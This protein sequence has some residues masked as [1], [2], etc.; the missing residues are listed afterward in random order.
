MRPEGT[1]VFLTYVSPHGYTFLD[2]RLYLPQSWCEDLAR[3]GR[4]G[5]TGLR[6]GRRPRGGEPGRSARGD[7]LAACPPRAGSAAR[8]GLLLLLGCRRP[9]APDAGPGGGSTLDHRAM[10]RRGKRGSGA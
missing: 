1:R 2:R 5:A 4:E 9:S 7:A 6:L 8:A 3:R 10:L